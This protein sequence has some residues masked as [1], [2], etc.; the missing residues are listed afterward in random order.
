MTDYILNTRT[1]SSKLVLAQTNINHEY[2]PTVGERPKDQLSAK[3]ASM[4]IERFLTSD[5]IVT[6]EVV[7]EGYTKKELADLL[8]ISLPVLEKLI[9]FLSKNSYKTID[10]EIVLPLIKLYCSTKWLGD[11]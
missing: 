9:D 2:E 3:T 1:Q 7:S 10:K 5:R 11:K 8:L 6:K 4:M